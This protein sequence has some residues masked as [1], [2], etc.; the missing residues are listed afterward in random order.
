MKGS[1]RQITRVSVVVCTYNRAY[2]LPA[3]IEAFR[4]VQVPLH[5]EWELLI[6]DNRSTDRTKEVIDEAK[7][8]CKLPIRYMYEPK[9][10]SSAARN[11]A[12]RESDGAIVAITDDDCFVSPSWLCGILREF[13]D[14]SVH[15]VGGRVLL[16]DTRD[17]PVSI[18][19]SEIPTD[20]TSPGQIFGTIP[21]C[22]MAFRREVFERI[23]LYD[24]DLG[25]GLRL[26]GEDADLIYRAIKA[27]FRLRYS[28]SFY[29][30][31][32]HGRRSN[33]ALLKLDRTYLLGR[34][35]VYAKHV[36]SGDLPMLKAAYWEFSRLARNAVRELL[37]ARSAR[38]PLREFSYLMQGFVLVAFRWLFFRAHRL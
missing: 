30:E 29:L 38:A 6:V 37:L 5:C 19:T 21:G 31:H 33:E 34:G 10:G 24:E 12:I 16:H 14:P 11:K 27:G 2:A 13:S 18:R 35:G 28:P 15:G 7:Q 26:A 23:G 25:A 20:V 8:N 32:N 3:L 1:D 4:R 17:L 9:P 22:N 36:L